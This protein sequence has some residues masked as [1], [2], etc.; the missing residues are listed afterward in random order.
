MNSF[1]HNL[2]LTTFGESHGPAIGGVLDGF[3]PGICV[4][5]DYI[6]DEV[7]LRKPIDT[8][9]GTQRR[10]CDDIEYLSGIFEGKT[11]GT[12]IAFIIRNR[13]TRSSDY[14]KIRH[15]YRPGH[16]D[17]T[18]DIKYG[19]R[20]YRGGGRASARETVA[21]VV[22]GAFAQMWLKTEGIRIY[23]YVEQIGN[24][25]L[26]QNYTHY[27]LDN[28]NCSPLRTLDQRTEKQMSQII[29]QVKNENDSI[30]GSVT[31]V[32]KGL[33]AGIGSPIFDKLQSSLAHA[34]FSIPAVK[35]F[36][37]GT[38]RDSGSI[39]GS[40]SNDEMYM[41]DG[42]PMFYTNHAGGILG[43]ISTGQD[44]YFK[45]AIKP[46]SSVS[47]KQRTITDN[48]EDSEIAITGRHD[49]CIAPRATSVIKAMTALVIADHLM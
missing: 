15:I 20:D 49:V 12:P 17:Y 47:H 43:G 14:D 37:Y 6:N 48:G 31:T 22:A 46:A 11:L 45:T 5:F 36:E 16:A 25:K 8:A 42:Q 29:A 30:G 19:L 4:D 28:A 21:R 24:I 35:S 7:A 10:E 18:Y 3:P 34:I 44:V 13:D 2:I 38:G 39:R 23:S 9:G 1:G 33:P 26:P 40:E 27:N 32:I 41:S